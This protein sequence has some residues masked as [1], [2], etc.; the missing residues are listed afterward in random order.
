MTQASSNHPFLSFML[1]A[2]LAALTLDPN[3]DVDDLKC[4]REAAAAMLAALQPRDA[5][6][7]ALAARVVVAH[8]AA[9][10]CFR[11]AALAE[12]SDLL[13]G[14]LF[15]KAMALSQRRNKN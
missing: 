4:E 10:E 11:R 6:E 14:R 2:V 15:A 9:M 3:R 12:V 13:M 8:H 7:A 5:I 1:N